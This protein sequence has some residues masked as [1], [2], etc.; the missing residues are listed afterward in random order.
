[1]RLEIAFTFLCVAVANLKASE[2]ANIPVNNDLYTFKPV[3]E[4]AINEQISLELHASLTYMT[5]A[6]HFGKDSKHKLGMKKFFLKN[7]EEERDHALKLMEYLISRSGS[8]KKLD[9]KMPTQYSWKNSLD[10]MQSAYGL[11]ADVSSNLLSLH[12]NVTGPFPDPHLA[13]LLESEFLREQV[14]SQR[15]LKGYI[16]MLEDLYHDSKHEK[17][18]IAE[19]L[20][21]QHLKED[22]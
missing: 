19:F 1:M 2:D 16:T 5:M 21:D 15:Q 11:E 8:L 12:R 18:G 17:H 3:I 6:A 20:F 9:V 13:D 22:K 7:S 14:E 4:A 10:A